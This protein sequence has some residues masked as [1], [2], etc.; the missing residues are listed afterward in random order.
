MFCCFLE[1]V[2]FPSI[3]EWMKSQYLVQDQ[4]AQLNQPQAPTIQQAQFI[5]HCFLLL[6][7]TLKSNSDLFENYSRATASEIDLCLYSEEERTSYWPA[8]ERHCGCN[9]TQN[10]SHKGKEVCFSLSGSS[11]RRLTEGEELSGGISDYAERCQGTNVKGWHGRDGTSDSCVNHL[12]PFSLTFTQRCIKIL[13]F[14]WPFYHSL[15]F[16]HGLYQYL[17]LSE[18]AWKA[19]AVQR[20]L[21]IDV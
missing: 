4:S 7:E 11:A 2:C 15:P 14:K 21:A 20:S 12:C 6:I 3:T 17:R 10:V 9:V 13:A 8:K 1:C 19:A 18:N 5:H 16:G